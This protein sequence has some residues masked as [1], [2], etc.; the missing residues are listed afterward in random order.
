MGGEGKERGGE[1]EGERRR[2]ERGEGGGGEEREEEGEEE[3]EGGQSSCLQ[4]SEGIPAVENH[5]FA[6]LTS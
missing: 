1:S 4:N 5:H 3:G 6:I 2:G